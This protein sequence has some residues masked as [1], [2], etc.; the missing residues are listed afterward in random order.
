MIS[1]RSDPSRENQPFSEAAL[2][3]TKNMSFSLLLRKL[4]LTRNLADGLFQ[5]AQTL[6]LSELHMRCCYAH[7]KNVPL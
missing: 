3:C 5:L 7:A 1:V 6:L 2:E 4:K